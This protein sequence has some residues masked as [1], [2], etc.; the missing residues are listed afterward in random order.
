ML[1]AGVEGVMRR[2]CEEVL[3]VLRANKEALLTVIEVSS[4]APLLSSC[5][6]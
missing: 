1:V 5:L 4:V 2:C 6:F 3:R